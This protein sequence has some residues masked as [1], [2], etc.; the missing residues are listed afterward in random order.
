MQRQNE[1][2]S[3]DEASLLQAADAN[4]AA[5]QANVNSQQATIDA[6]ER[7]EEL[8]RRKEE[9]AQHELD[10]REK[11]IHDE[12]DGAIATAQKR[13]DGLQ[14]ASRLADHNAEIEE[15]P[16]KD[17][18]A[19]AQKEVDAAQSRSDAAQT[20]LTNSQTALDNSQTTL[21]NYTK[22]A[23]LADDR[24]TTEQKISDEIDNQRQ[25]LDAI[26]QQQASSNPA[27]SGP[28]FGGADL[29]KQ[30]PAPFTDEQLDTFA[31]QLGDA[32]KSGWTQFTDFIKNT[33]WIGLITTPLSN[34]L[35]DAVFG[36]EGRPDLA[37]GVKKS[38]DL[39]GVVDEQSL[40]IKQHHA[41]D[42]W[43]WLFTGDPGSLWSGVG[44]F[45]KKQVADPLSGAIDGV[46]QVLSDVGS[47][48]DPTNP[49]SVFFK[50]GNFFDPSNPDSLPAKV[51]NAFDP[52][53][54]NSIPSTVGKFAQDVTDAITRPFED[55]WDFLF[56]HSL[57]PDLLT[58]I[59]QFFTDLP[60]D[61]GKLAGDVLSS[62][63]KPFQDAATQ[64][65]DKTFGFIG[66]IWS[67]VTGGFQ[68][69]K[70]DAS[71]TIEDFLSNGVTLF[72]NARDAI[73][74]ATKQG[75]LIW[76]IKEGA[77]TLLGKLKDGVVGSD[78]KTGIVGD[79]VTGITSM[80]GGA[81]TTVTDPTGGT[82]AQMG[83][84][85]KARA[86]EMQTDLL[87]EGAPV[88]QTKEGMV[89]AFQTAND[90]ITNAT[91]GPLS[92]MGSGLVTI[93]GN[94]GAALFGKDGS[95]G[96]IAT[97]GQGVR[98]A[99]NLI[100][101]PQEQKD[102][103]LWL[104]NH[105]AKPGGN[106]NGGFFPRMEWLI[107][108]VLE[109]QRTETWKDNF[110]NIRDTLLKF[111][112]GD[113]DKSGQGGFFKPILD[114]FTDLGE[115]IAKA[116]ADGMR[117]QIENIQKAGKDIVDAAYKGADDAAGN[118]R[119]PAPRFIPLGRKS[120]EGYA[121]GFTRATAYVQQMAARLVDVAARM[122]SAPSLAALNVPVGISPVGALVGA[123][124]PGAGGT[125]NTQNNYIGI[126]QQNYGSSTPR[127]KEE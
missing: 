4:V 5:A 38:L 57:F 65:G 126:L 33:D 3:R 1:E 105:D 112:R 90:I 60:G 58:A 52:A 74:G 12:T 93:L 91:S 70:D 17:R 44:D 18:V 26:A 2:M 104:L 92:T 8:A 37:E 108:F 41:D 127:G 94:V 69:T 48:L 111:F 43:G 24:L 124:A 119:S 118:P 114:T 51:G 123:G 53:N 32:L 97:L 86:S 25:L 10:T 46:G 27:A 101:G 14:A 95:G 30:L 75:G 125:S 83:R 59:E 61:I 9:S 116:M 40:F 49:S 34:A 117:S 113:D 54:P 6:L 102:S 35:H 56:G 71:P 36:G 15:R 47:G 109:Y 28:G 72:T 100:F 66:D 19:T 62:I 106:Q 23:S 67:G 77:T 73:V 64:I 120:G 80:F 98:A 11:A 22:A 99:F 13:L 121:Y 16:L 89:S 68:S 78:G 96:A 84:D 7:D 107:N 88:P 21:D 20:D 110:V 50:V 63:T 85:A 103:I 87:G 79:I 55:A 115:K 76:D 39:P 81:K 82:L 45:F 29:D 122:M 42:F 31:T